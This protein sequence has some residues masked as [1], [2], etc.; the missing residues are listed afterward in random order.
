M[1]PRGDTA[2]F[3]NA[4]RDPKR[5]KRMLGAI[6][7][8][9]TEPVAIMEVCG[10]HTRTIVRYGLEQLLPKEI[11]FLHGPGCPVCVTPR[12]RVDMAVALAQKR[13][14]VLA[15]LGD[16]LRVPGS[17]G[18]L[19]QARASGCDIRVVYSPLDVLALAKQNQK[20]RSCSSPSGSRRP[21]RRRRRFW[22]AALWKEP[23]TSRCS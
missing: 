2:S 12:E 19:L 3:L 14:L 18:S 7:E 17:S 16:M 4:L 6:K 13:G 10:G 23:K 22:N 9:T 11:S 5:A 15:T 21:P 8:L 1:T 20:T